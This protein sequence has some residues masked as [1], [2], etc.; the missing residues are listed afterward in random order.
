[1]TDD[2]YFDPPTPEEANQPGPVFPAGFDSE[3]SEG[4]WINE[5]ED[6]RADGHGGF[7]HPFCLRQASR[8][9]VWE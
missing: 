4:D 7:A 1:M 9:V 8:K 2:D 3:C 5:G 6:I